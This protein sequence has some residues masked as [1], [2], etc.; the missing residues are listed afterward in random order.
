MP[1]NSGKKPPHEVVDVVLR[2]GTIV[3]GIKVDGWR[4]SPWPE[5]EH[6][7]DIVRWQ[8]PK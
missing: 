8:L 3:R 2:N 4:W 1:A 6:P 5:G 7:F